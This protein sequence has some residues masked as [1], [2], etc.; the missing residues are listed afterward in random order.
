MPGALFE[1][2]DFTIDSTWLCGTALKVN[3]SGKE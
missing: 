3:W 1:A 2:I